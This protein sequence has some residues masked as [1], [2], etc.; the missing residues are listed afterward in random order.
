MSASL[1]Q[2]QKYMSLYG[3][4]TFYIF[5]TFGNFILICILVQRTHRRNSCSLYLL[6][7]TIVNFILIQCIL[8][9]AVYSA[10]HIDPQNVSL[11]WC[12]IRSYLFNGLLM[13]YR[14]YKMAACIDRAAM[15]SRHARIRSFSDPRIACRTILIITII[16]VLIP[17]HLAVYFRIEFGRC[18]PQLG[19]Y[20]KLYSAY[21]I[22]IAGWSPPI[23]MA[24][25]GT[26]AYLNLKKVK[27]KFV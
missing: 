2:A 19:L 12:K 9:L 25:F 20:A 3:L 26:I 7:A 24:I 8:P 11:I 4:S 6:A 22:L 15:C 14:W 27:R 23:V 1:A 10:D 21:S 5:G 18:G 13:L 17:I 16:W